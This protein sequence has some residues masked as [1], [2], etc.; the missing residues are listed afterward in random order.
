MQRGMPGRT[1]HWN[2]GQDTW[3]TQCVWLWVPVGGASWGWMLGNWEEEEKR[4][5]DAIAGAE[6]DAAKATGGEANRTT[7]LRSSGSKECKRMIP[8]KLGEEYTATRAMTRQVVAL[9]GVPSHATRSGYWAP[10]E[11]SRLP[12]VHSRWCS[13]SK[14]RGREA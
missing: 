6:R 13:T 2:G 9:D 1:H 3:T 10:G 14:A 8:Y 7:I 5:G 12:N 4:E 11:T